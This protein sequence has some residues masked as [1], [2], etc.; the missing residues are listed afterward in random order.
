MNED[1]YLMPDVA[2]ISEPTRPRYR[3]LESPQG[4][5]GPP[6]IRRPYG[7]PPPLS[8]EQQQIWLQTQLTDSVP[9]YNEVLI[10][11]RTGPLNRDALGRSFSEVTRRHAALRT[12]FPAGD[13]APIQLIAEHKSTTVPLTDLNALP[14]QQRNAE[15]LRIS[16]E[17]VRRPFDL[18]KGPLVRARLLRLS[19]ENYVLIVTLHN[20]VA[21][22]WSLNILARELGELYHAYS[23]GGPSP[24]SDLPIEYADYAHWQRH[25]FEGDVLEQHISYW[26]KRLTGM[27]PVLDLPTDRPR[28]PVQAFR[29]A[30]QSLVLSKSLT[31]SLMKLSAREA[32]T[33]V[34]TLLAAFQ[35][36]LSRYTGQYDIAVGS[37]LPGRERVGTEDLIGPFAHTVMIRTDAVGDPTFRELLSRMRNVVPGDCE[38]QNVPFDYV[39][40][41]LP[42][43]SD[44]SRNPLVRVLFS[45]TPSI[46]LAR[47]GWK[48]IDLEV[49]DGAASVDLQLQ[50]YERADSIVGRFTYDTDLFDAATISRMAG[51]FQTLLQDAVANPDQRL[52]RLPLLTE[53]ERHQLLVEW[54]NTQVDYPRDSCVHQLFEAQAG[55]TPNAIA[56]VF[57]KQFLTYSELNTRANQLAHS[58]QKLGVG[59]DV[60]VG[61]C[62]ER[63]LEMLVGLLGILKAG[64]AYVPLDPAYPPERL[65]FMLEDAKVPVLLTQNRLVPSLAES[66]ARVV[67]LDSGW[68]EIAKESGENPASKAKSEDLAY[69]LYTSGSTGKPKG[70]QI[71]HRAVVNF[72]T[73][74]S[75]KPG[76]TCRDR[77]LAVT[78]L[79][80]DIA[81][82]EI[83]LPLSLGASLEI[84]RREVSSDGNLLL[85]KLASSGATV[86]QAT[87]ATWRMLLEAGW[88]GSRDLKVLCGGEAMPRE[89]AG[90]LLKRASSVWNMYGPTET[91]IWSTTSRITSSHGPITVGKP[92]A[93]TEIY[94]MDSHSQPVPVGIPG[95]LYIGGDGVARGYFHR[96]DLTAEKFV[97]NPFREQ[98][99]G[100]RLYRTGD[101]VRYQP[102][103]EIECLGR[104]DHQ[105]K[106]RG[107]RIELGEIEAVLS[108]HPGVRQNVVT[109]REDVSG[110]R[111]LVA[112][113]TANQRQ[114]PPTADALRDFLKPKL[115]D[116]MLPSQFIFLESLPLT[117]NGKVDRKALP[118][119]TQLGFTQQ[120]E[121]VAPRNA[122]ESQLVK[123]WESVLSIRPVGVKENFFELGGHSLLVTKLNRR[124]EQAFAKKLSMAAIF[125]APT[126]EQQASLLSNGSAFQ[127]RSAV[128]PIQPAGSRP[129]FFCLGYNAGPIFLPLAGC[130]GPDQPLLC[131][132]PSLLAPNQ[133]PVHC[134]M[135]DVAACLAKEIR[136]LQPHGPYYLGGFCGGGLVAYAIASEL[137]AQGGKIAVLALFEPHTC[138]YDHIK[139]SNGSGLGRRIR[140]LKF[141]VEN[142]QELE[143]KQAP[144]YI[145]HRAR[146]H[147]RYLNGVF[148]HS[149]NRLG[150]H[151]RNGRAR[152]I[153][154]ILTIAY[155]GYRPQPFTGPMALFQGTRREPG[156][157]WERRY[158]GELAS[159]LTIYEIPGYSNWPTSFFVQPNVEILGNKLA[160]YFPDWPG[161]RC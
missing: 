36:L 45:F 33:P 58:L 14:D 109:A 99:S 81:G 44:P 73:S 30:C 40:R 145:R 110:D 138:Y 27:A 155:H 28:A 23:T 83:Y 121:Y 149:L 90:E 107:F 135:E 95:E 77:L 68:H 1:L 117:P 94:V 66:S 41:E 156:S 9:L 29:G 157:E 87:P 47:L 50:L 82:L 49:D 7:A 114:S 57:E 19:Q 133:L 143:F 100:A 31:E 130:L 55:R 124:I 42:G 80:F 104:I 52:S 13:G 22:D 118:V 75:L 4:P 56:V 71:P 43:E 63:S 134:T 70:V 103:G 137:M 150:L 16:T 8:F 112:Y 122:I 152:D 113:V 65:S 17:E 76:M 159:T 85:S 147:F 2:Q 54:N 101:L 34:V 69:V 125:E 26:Q 39:V 158:W 74:M 146:V 151:P 86:L 25:W 3:Y 102:N 46:S 79:S 48:I 142:L 84:V 18:A 67:C 141:H 6:V 131:V 128:I 88:E 153:G 111:R 116:Y 72:L 140:M 38:H 64:G 132:D 32:V 105:V 108:Q 35:A 154:E 37:I 96:P 161:V 10:L 127:W 126:V 51:H 12:T 24:L 53:A 97:P 11:E 139:Y 98:E 15:V 89:L 148:W 21:D 5:S 20:I 136:E 123:I 144:A 92:I 93:N 91:T 78:T 115:P 160:A 62:V 129:P 119:P 120:K 106:V 60:L 59:P 61:I